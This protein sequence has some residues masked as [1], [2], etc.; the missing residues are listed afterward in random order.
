M[1]TFTD[2]VAVV[3]LAWPVNDTGGRTIRVMQDAAG[4]A[5]SNAGYKVTTRPAFHDLAPA[6]GGGYT[7]TFTAPAAPPEPAPEEGP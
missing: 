4:A 6:E 1:I 7:F 5:L 3:K 2:G